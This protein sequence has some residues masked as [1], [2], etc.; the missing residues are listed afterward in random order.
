[1]LCGLLLPVWAVSPDSHLVDAAQQ[2]HQSTQTHAWG[3]ILCHGFHISMYIM[4]TLGMYIMSTHL[5]IFIWNNN[6]WIS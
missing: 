2:W 3:F 6:H 4:S 5:S 1:M